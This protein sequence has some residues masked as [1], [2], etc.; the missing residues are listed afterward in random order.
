MPWRLLLLALLT[1]LIAGLAPR[2]RAADDP[3]AAATGRW[4]LETL[5]LKSGK[6]YQGLVQARRE[7]EIDFAEIVQRP[8]KPTFAIIRGINTPQV[9]NLE[10]LPPSQHAE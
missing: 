7:K 4:K 1:P 8:G 10:M 6:Q 5:V 3:P 2:A 9:A